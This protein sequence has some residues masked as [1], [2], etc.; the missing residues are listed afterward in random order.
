MLLSHII[1]NMIWNIN[2]DFRRTV[3][4]GF[5]ILFLL[6]SVTATAADETEFQV[7]STNLQIYRDGLVRVTQTLIVNDTVPALTL[8]LLNSSVNN[9]IVLDE[10]QTVLD[11][12]VNGINLT[13]FTLGTTSVSLQYDT[14]S[15]TKKD[16]DV[17]TFLVDTPYN[18]TVQ[19]PEST[20]VYLSETPTSIDTE[21]NKITLSLFPSQWEISY[22]IP[23][24]PPADFQISDLNVTPSEVEAGEEVTVSVKIT[25]VGGQTGSY[26]L[27]L[28]INQT[29]EDTK[30]VTLEEGASNI[31]EFKVIKQTAGKYNIEIAGLVDEF[32]VRA[33]SS[34]GAPSDLIP[35]EYFVAAAA[36]VAAIFFVVFLLFRRR[37][38][39]IE[40]IFKMHPRLNKEEK[41]V[42]QFLAENEGKAFESQ[43]RERFPDIPR[44]SLWRLVKRLE[45]LEILKVKKI[46]LENQVELKK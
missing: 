4:V 42:I 41:E 38:Y 1:L 20:V 34:N 16:F 40:K 22:I 36:A 31:T 15:L 26:T 24:V 45:K 29:T 25:N 33:A 44:T 28:I 9:F 19:L 32:T 37:G 6:L 23:L 46:G 8:P 3:F 13:V 11:Y 35:V 7:E 10:N 18:L 5:A 21:D 30:T 2:I 12:E 14:N 43:I 27:P 17:W 39:N